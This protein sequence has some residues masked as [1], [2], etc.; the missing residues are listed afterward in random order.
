[1]CEKTYVEEKIIKKWT[2]TCYFDKWIILHHW[3]TMDWVTMHDLK[4]ER[5]WNNLDEL[6]VFI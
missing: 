6:I 1:M 3:M 4:R 2:T 5:M